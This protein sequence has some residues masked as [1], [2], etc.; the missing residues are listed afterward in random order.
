[1]VFGNERCSTLL[2]REMSSSKTVVGEISWPI[3]PELS[4]STRLAGSR[5]AGKVGRRAEVHRPR[6]SG[7]PD[8]G[9]MPP[10]FYVLLLSSVHLSS[11]PSISLSCLLLLCFYV[12]HASHVAIQQL[13]SQ[14]FGYQTRDPLEIFFRFPYEN[15]SIDSSCTGE[16][17]RK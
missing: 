12:L 5:L 11:F 8:S 7:R 17:S 13:G 4:K 2:A 10:R 16:M 14:S 3:P 1:M 6:P 9:T 15:S